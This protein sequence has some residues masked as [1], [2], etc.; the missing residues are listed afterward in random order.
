MAVRRE[1][2]QKLSAPTL[3]AAQG[4]Q[5]RLGVGYEFLTRPDGLTRFDS[6][7]HIQ[8]HDLP[9]TMDLGLLYRALNQKQI[10]MAAANTT[11]GLLTSSRYTVLEDDRRAFPPYQACFVVS[12][13]ALHRYPQ[14]QS[15]LESLSNTL[16]ENS[17]RQLNRKVDL[18]HISVTRVAADFLATLE[19]RDG[20]NTMRS[21]NRSALEPK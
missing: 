5:W 20:P 15:A 8:W 21:Y 17:M 18:D 2:A 19:A 3:S 4:R 14:L 16:N 12:Q 1:D 10:D 11:D 7:Y 6:I 9:H 13:S